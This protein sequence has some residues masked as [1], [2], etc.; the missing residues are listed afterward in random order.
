MQ[1]SPNPPSSR[2][3][4]RRRT[5]QDVDTKGHDK[6][7]DKKVGNGQTDDKVVGGC[8]QGSFT[9]DAE[10]DEHIAEYC[11]KREEEEKQGPIIFR[12]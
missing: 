5:Y 7:G 12:L 9:V 6:S 10:N 3:E 1:S 4:F 8:L 11:Q 2:N